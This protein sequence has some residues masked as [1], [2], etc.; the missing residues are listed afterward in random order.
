MASSAAK[1]ANH[2]REDP[3]DVIW[4]IAEIAKVIRRSERQTYHLVATGKLPVKKFGAR[5]CASRRALQELF[6]AGA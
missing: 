1:P 5:Y 3:I 6:G 2:R 4:G